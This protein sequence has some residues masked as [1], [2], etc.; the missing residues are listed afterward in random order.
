MQT[1]PPMT[2]KQ[3]LSQYRDAYRDLDIQWTELC[4]LRAA[5]TRITSSINPDASGGKSSDDKLSRAVAKMVDKEVAIQKRIGELL[6]IRQDIERA[7][8]SVEDAKL[9]TILRYRYILGKKWYEIAET[10]GYDYR[11]VTRLHGRALENVKIRP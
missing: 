4:E 7:I 6:D 3:Y 1:K 9:Q 10:M 5:A 8:M 11:W 2:P